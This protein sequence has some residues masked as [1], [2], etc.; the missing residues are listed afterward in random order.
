MPP[1][2]AKGSSDEEKAILD[3]LNRTNRPYNASDISSQLHGLVSPA[4]AKKLLND[5][6][7][8]GK[9][10]VK[11]N[12]KLQI[13][14]ANQDSIEVPNIEDA[15]EEEE[16][17]REMEE[18]MN[19]LKEDNKVL[20]GRL[21]GLNS[22]LTDDQ[23]RELIAKKTLEMKTNEERLVQMRSG[24]VISPQEKKKIDTEYNAMVKQWAARKRMFKNISDAIAEGYPGKLKDLFE[25]LGVETDENCGV[26]ISIL[27]K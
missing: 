23:M 19:K 15:E 9:I 11:T 10:I 22:A 14:Y 4:Q 6:A 12:N 24:D 1:K 20:S 26:D 7:E 18:R 27:T 3:Y 16:S 25:D 5:L 2:K 13:F 8:E 21:Q 17:I